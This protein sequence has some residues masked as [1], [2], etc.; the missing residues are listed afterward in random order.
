[1]VLAS[2]A[3][4]ESQAGAEAAFEQ[5]QLRAYA[6]AALQVNEVQQKWAPRLQRA[7]PEQV[8]ELQ[9]EMQGELV[10]VVQGTGLSVQEYN[11]ILNASKAQPEL[12]GKIHEHMQEVVD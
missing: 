6:V 10:E 8:P 3:V 5:E 4:A 11:E 1:V 7:E 12:R 2:S 9:Q